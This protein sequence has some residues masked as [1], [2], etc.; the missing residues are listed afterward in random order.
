MPRTVLIA[1]DSQFMRFVLKK[2]LEKNG[3]EVAAVMGAGYYPFGNALS[4]IDP[5]HSAF[6]T[7]KARKA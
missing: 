4:A 1:D 6:I 3:F 7:I 2:I 5:F